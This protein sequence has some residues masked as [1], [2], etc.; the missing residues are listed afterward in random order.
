MNFKGSLRIDNM[1]ILA[2]QILIGY[3]I[4]LWIFRKKRKH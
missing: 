1:D 3:V 4:A 2:I